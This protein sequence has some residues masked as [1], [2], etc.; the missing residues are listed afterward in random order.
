[1]VTCHVEVDPPSKINYLCFLVLK[2]HKAEKEL[3]GFLFFFTEIDLST[4]IVQIILE[5]SRSI[6]TRQMERR[7][8]SITTLVYEWQCLFTHQG[9]FLF[10]NARVALFFA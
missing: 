7:S 4:V 1:M 3:G 6:P 5:E 2:E 9:H 8:L 10:I